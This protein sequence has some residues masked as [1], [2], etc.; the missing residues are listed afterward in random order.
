MEQKFALHDVV[1]DGT[2][3]GV[4][5]GI[6]DL[7]GGIAYSVR[8]DGGRAVRFE[9]DLSIV[10]KYAPEAKSFSEQCAEYLKGNTK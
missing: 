3:E 5:A 1:T 4:I 8:F 6:I 7:D 9:R 2:Y 10:R